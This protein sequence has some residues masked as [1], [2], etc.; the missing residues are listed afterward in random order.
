[1]Q[2]LSLLEILNGFQEPLLIRFRPKQVGRFIN[3][4]HHDF[5]VF[6]PEKGFQGLDELLIQLI[7]MKSVGG[8]HAS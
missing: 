4:A 1:M 5:D 7:R 2:I 8:V 6:V 3:L